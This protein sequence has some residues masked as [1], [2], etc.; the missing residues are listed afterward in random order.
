MDVWPA[1]LEL[2]HLLQPR[3]LLTLTSEFKTQ[4][5]GRGRFCKEQT[6]S[7]E[8]QIFSTTQK[9][10]MNRTLSQTWPPKWTLGITTQIPVGFAI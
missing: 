4:D 1:R 10:G 6:I 9:P 2:I 5:P 3:T 7:H 8:E